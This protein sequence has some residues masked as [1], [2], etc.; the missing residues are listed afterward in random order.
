[1]SCRAQR[2]IGARVVRPKKTR[3]ARGYGANHQA[4]RKVCERRIRAGDVGC[5]RCGRLIVPG[6]PWDL[7]HDD[8][9]RSRHTGAE[10]RRCNRAAG[11]RQGAL[12]R[13]GRRRRPSVQKQTNGDGPELS[14]YRGPNGEFWSRAWFFL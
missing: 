8:I 3:Q 1:M 6:A 2:P 11:G 9:D 13:N 12:A 14:P 5:V 10:H 4:L 7:G